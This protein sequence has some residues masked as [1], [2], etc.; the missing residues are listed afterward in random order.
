V[1]GCIGISNA[2]S[3]TIRSK[4]REDFASTFGSNKKI[5]LKAKRVA[6]A[7]ADAPVRT[8]HAP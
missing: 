2:E 4:L 8:Q 5:L 3:F 7:M 1:K 6:K